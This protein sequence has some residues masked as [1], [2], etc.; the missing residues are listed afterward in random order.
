MNFTGASVPTPHPLL[1]PRERDSSLNRDILRYA[2]PLSVYLR[3]EESGQWPNDIE[4]IEALKAAFYVLLSRELKKHHST[5]CLLTK[6][7]LDVFLEGLVFRI[8]IYLP[9]E[10]SARE[11]FISIQ[12]GRALQREGADMPAHWAA[13]RGLQASYNA[14]GITVRLAKY[15][16][17][18]QLLSACLSEPVVELLVASLFT[19]PEPFSP[20][21]S[22]IIG[23][24]RFLH[25]LG[26]YR[27]SSDPL[28]VDVNEELTVE[29]SNEI[30]A[31]FNLVRRQEGGES[32]CA[33]FIATPRDLRS[34]HWTRTEPSPMNLHRII[35]LATQCVE[36]LT[37]SLSP[38]SSG[39][40]FSTWREWQTLFIA[41]LSDF[42]AVL[43][44]HPDLVPY[45][46]GNNV[47]DRVLKDLDLSVT[48]REPT[49][50]AELLQ[51][52]SKF[53]NFGDSLR[54]SQLLVGLHP[55]H[56]L[57]EE[58]EKHF[59]DIA[60][61]FYGDSGIHLVGIVWKPAAFLPQVV[62]PHTLQYSMP[63]PVSSHLQSVAKRT[64]RTLQEPCQS[65]KKP[66]II[67]NIFDIVS[68]IRTI[69]RGLVSDVH[70][71][72]GAHKLQ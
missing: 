14:F 61:F 5:D 65:G 55:V 28:I 9:K 44:L 22:H 32:H 2:E 49:E 43:R 40:H 11:Q 4:A 69:G 20:P 71:I 57:I 41:P 21:R 54:P 64:H 53:K 29:Q 13:M 42:D 63:L 18:S 52:V 56:K 48:V 30:H 72:K 59:G 34:M 23:F 39:S 51:H 25:L 3:L 37:A 17:H 6:S 36:R 10:V 12:H 1:I 46:R 58:L 35:A 62:K 38:S 60:M 66:F 31:Q 47:Y 15:W 45:G 67:R 16:V 26:S 70:F 8:R 33:M 50:S 19:S 24:V 68:D 27:W 7:H